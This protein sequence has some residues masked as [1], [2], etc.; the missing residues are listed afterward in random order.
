MSCSRKRRLGL[1]VSCLLAV[2]A[3]PALGQSDAEKALD[4]ARKSFAEEQFDKARDLLITASQTDAKNPDIRLLL[5]KAHYQLGELNEAMAAWRAVLRL[6]P[7]QAYA[8]RMLET[9]TGKT[10]D[11][12]ARLQVVAGLLRDRILEPVPRELA[13]IQLQTL[14]DDQRLLL[15]QVTA[16]YHL[17]NHKPQSALLALGEA[18]VRFP[19]KQDSPRTRLLLARAQVAVGGESLAPGLA[20]LQTLAKE[21]AQTPIGPAAELEG[22][23]FRL[24]Q[25]AADVKELTAWMTKHKDHPR[26]SRAR[27]ELV[28]AIQRLLG[29]TTQGPTLKPEDALSD[30]DAKALAAA[31]TAY[32]AMTTSADADA[33]TQF[34]LKHL[35]T[36][37]VARK[38]YQ[39]ANSGVET[40]EKLPLPLASS[41][42]VVA[43]RKRLDV[44]AAAAELGKIAAR[45]SQHLD[46]TAAMKTWLE[47][48]PDHPQVAEARQA[49]LQWYLAAA[50]RLKAPVK[51]SPLHAIDAAAIQVAVAI[52]GE[53][54]TPADALKLTERLAVHV[55]K[56]YVA[57]GSLA[58]AI[59][60]YQKILA[61]ELP[62]TSRAKALR[63]LAAA[64]TQ[65]A[66][67]KLGSDATEQRIAAGPLPQELKAVTATLQQ[68]NALTPAE[69]TW[70][71]QAALAV[72]VAGLSNRLPWPASPAAPKPTQSWAIELALPVI[73]DGGD[74]LAVKSAAVV[75]DAIINELAALPQST[76]DGLAISVH[77]KHL[78]VLPQ[79]EDA[80]VTAM[81]RRADLLTALANRI[82]QRNAEAGL[83][84]ANGQLNDPQKQ[85]IET[86]K[87][88]VA[89]RPSQ[90]TTAI[91]KLDAA[92]ALH[93]ASGRFEVAEAA[94][95]ALKDGLPARG[96]FDVELA[97]IKLMVSQ[98]SQRDARTTAMGF[99]VPAALDPQIAKA[100]LR[101]YELQ[102]G[103]LAGDPRLARIRPLGDGVAAYY[104]GLKM[105]AVAEKAIAVKAEKAVPVADKYAQFQQAGLK[106]FLAERELSRLLQSFRGREKITFTPAFEA[107]QTAFEKFIAAHPS[108]PLA[109]QAVGKLFEIGRL[110]ERHERGQVAATVYRDLEKFAAGVKQLGQAEIGRSTTAERAALSAAVAL[111][112]DAARA[113]RKQLAGQPGDAP[114]P[115]AISDEFAQAI[116]AYQA[117]VEKY[118]SGPLVKTAITGRLALGVHGVRIGAWD[119]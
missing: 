119:A 1:V 81:A 91:G 66:L 84:D 74:A 108:D 63:E 101:L 88:L 69:A 76:A 44:Q 78:A 3:A 94:Q 117:V 111:D 2:A 38:A 52:F 48:H 105:F 28:L 21:Q 79:G 80:W 59:D 53:T 45:L 19:E 30:D 10:L 98:V 97:I 103:I 73:A 34:I 33:L 106:L 68:I 60:A 31:A 29:D 42:L 54:K 11:A 70:K 67:L 43:F 65:V 39:A 36:R 112:Q 102:R 13:Q 55:Q 113:L 104:R 51:E 6:A 100:L 110:F 89:A 22:I 27:D 115:K 99:Q 107:A 24:R 15:L 47:K 109:R 20:L 72:Q 37:Y 92:L 50:F 26:R 64:Q 96:Q 46:A 17:E 57:A 49:L 41:R 118:P 7:N 71:L 82:F 77:A 4:A 75:L 62:A 83:G 12:D 23:A 90:A 85:L 9:L 95:A 58:A 86:I 5:G 25:R 61:I 18:A 14:S 114:P 35:E 8:K 40:L 56:R 16:E 116:T 93:V 87:T 32:S